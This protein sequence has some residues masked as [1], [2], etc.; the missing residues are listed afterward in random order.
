MRA[1]DVRE[2]GAD[3]QGGVRRK[4]R[5]ARVLPAAP[6]DAHFARLRKRRARA[7]E[8]AS[9]EGLK[10]RVMCAEDANGS[11]FLGQEAPIQ[12]WCFPF[13]RAW[14]L[15]LEGSSAGKIAAHRLNTS[16][17]EAPSPLLSVAPDAWGAELIIPLGAALRLDAAARSRAGRRGRR[18]ADSPQLRSM[19]PR[20]ARPSARDWAGKQ[21]PRS[22]PSLAVGEF[23]L[24]QVGPLRGEAKRRAHR[25]TRAN[26]VQP[27]FLIHSRYRARQAQIYF[28]RKSLFD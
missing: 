26:R 8:R 20:A 9:I 11:S 22:S 15:Y 14:P 18:S 17:C 10:R 4:E 3:E 5:G 27:R 2:V 23:G 21:P 1:E 7:D 28:W 25:S 19:K 16:A 6:H 12:C 13:F 24:S